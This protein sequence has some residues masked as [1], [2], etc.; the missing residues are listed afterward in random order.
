MEQ[1]QS[2]DILI[3]KTTRI[4]PT[5]DVY[6]V[7]LFRKIDSMDEL[8]VHPHI[9][10]LINGRVVRMEKIDNFRFKIFVSVATQSDAT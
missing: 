9:S 6:R 2:F 4:S 5:E 7:T 3:R 10:A 1:G 8:L